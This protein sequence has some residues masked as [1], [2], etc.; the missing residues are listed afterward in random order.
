MFFFF[1]FFFLFFFFCGSR[2]FFIVVIVFVLRHV[3]PVHFRVAVVCFVVLVSLSVIVIVLCVIFLFFFVLGFAGEHDFKSDSR[4][5]NVFSL[6]L[7]LVLV[8]LDLV[9]LS[10]SPF[11]R[12]FKSTVDGGS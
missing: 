8:S 3:L 5:D 4:D 12:R 7:N 1:F 2:F 9:L 11:P 10:L 6:V